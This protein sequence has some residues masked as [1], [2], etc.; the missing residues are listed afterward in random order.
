MFCFRC[1]KQVADD[2]DYC[3]YC[4]ARL[5][6]GIPEGKREEKKRRRMLYEEPECIRVFSQNNGE[7]LIRDGQKKH[8]IRKNELFGL[9]WVHF[10]V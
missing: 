4:G 10:Y 7:I 9:C 8:S 6:E 2:A 1:G 5:E 3:P